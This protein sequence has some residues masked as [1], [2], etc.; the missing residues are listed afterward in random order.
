MLQYLYIEMF[1]NCAGFVMCYFSLFYVVYY[2]FV[3]SHTGANN[4]YP[5]DNQLF[6]GISATTSAHADNTGE[7]VMIYVVL[8]CRM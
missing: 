5:S 3:H 6:A 2:F 7:C 4:A 8:L 1:Y